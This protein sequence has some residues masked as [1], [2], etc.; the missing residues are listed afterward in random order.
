MSEEQKEALK[1]MLER[2]F[3]FYCM[4][5]TKA[6]LTRE[7]HHKIADLLTED[8]ITNEWETLKAHLEYDKAQGFYGSKEMWDMI[9]RSQDRTPVDIMSLYPLPDAIV[10]ALLDA[11][12]I[13][14]NPY[15]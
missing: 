7:D 9:Q 11:G 10:H 14:K 6:R 8:L 5:S 12:T 4:T 1:H 2:R 3:K 15:V 13:V